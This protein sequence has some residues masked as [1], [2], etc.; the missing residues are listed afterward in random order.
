VTAHGQ[1]LLRGAT[2][3]CDAGNHRNPG[4]ASMAS[5]G[6]VFILTGSRSGSTLLRF[7]LDTHPDLGCPPETSMT[8]AALHLLRS[9]DVLDRAGLNRPRL[10]TDQATLPQ[11]AL[12]AV[13]HAMDTAYGSYLARRGK[14]RWCDKSLDNIGNA[15]VLGA[16]YPD[17]Q[18]LCLY[19]HCMDVIASGIEMCPWG[20]SGFGFS[21]Y[22]AEHPGN[23]V[24]A[25]ANYWKDTTR[26]ILQHE[27]L[28]TGR[29][30]RIRYEDLVSAPE[31]VTREALSFLGMK[32]DPE[33]IANCFDTPHDTHGPGD[34]KIWF[35]SSIMTN[36]IG[37][38]VK[39]PA[40]LLSEPTRNAVNELLE[41]LDYRRIDS[42][43]N[44]TSGPFDPRQTR[45]VWEEI[46]PPGPDG[47]APVNIA[48]R[49]AAASLHDVLEAHHRD[50][51]MVAARW[52]NLAGER[53]TLLVE[54]G[55]DRA[56]CHWIFPAARSAAG[57]DGSLLT[58]SA[59]PATW[60]AILDRRAN[61]MTELRSG[62]LR[63]SHRD[64][65]NWSRSE[66]LHAVGWLLD[67]GSA[68]TRFREPA[69]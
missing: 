1:H 4:V 50:D 19:R 57:A 17:A 35:T 14:K 53:L 2:L 62:S 16:L 6:P 7:V 3:G 33:I 26:T 51:G 27:Q 38:G 15:N 45:T 42:D 61:L 36:S 29:C 39:V 21:P 18:Y 44:R 12:E 47:P 54:E 43:W 46:Q 11:E 48:I 69:S 49:R 25:I 34:E 10:A 37:R 64:G 13:R 30:H 41:T 63:C 66:A 60:L 5:A 59:A 67:L 52:P 68:N 58:V 28:L 55:T 56:E 31:Q 23:D 8:A 65:L 22:A 9:W 20:L 32:A 40:G 24:E